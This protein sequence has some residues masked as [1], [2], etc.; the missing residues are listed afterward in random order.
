MGLELAGTSP[1]HSLLVHPPHVDWDQ[2]NERLYDLPRRPLLHRLIIRQPRPV[3]RTVRVLD[4]FLL[5]VGRL[6]VVYHP[7][8][9]GS[10]TGFTHR[11]GMETLGTCWIVEDR[12]FSS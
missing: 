5:H 11:L 7:H 12:A 4:K 8:D 10:Q 9:P 1:E 2:P 6:C 3:E